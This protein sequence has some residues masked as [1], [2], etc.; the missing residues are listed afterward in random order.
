[1]FNLFEERSLII[2]ADVKLCLSDDQHCILDMPIFERQAVPKPLCNNELGFNM[3]SKIEK[4]F[5]SLY[6]TIRKVK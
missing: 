4:K 5:N 2:D 1:M 3:K 6:N